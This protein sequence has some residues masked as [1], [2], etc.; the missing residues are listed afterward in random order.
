M[1]VDDRQTRLEELLSHQQHLIDAL[2]TEVADQRRELRQLS[3]TVSGLE[4]KIKLLAQCVER[5]AEDLPH[6]KPPHY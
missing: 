5:S 2:D 4:A 3:L 6:E 1:S